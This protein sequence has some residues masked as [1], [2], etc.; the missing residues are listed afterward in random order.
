MNE[1]LKSVW[2][3]TCKRVIAIE[4]ILLFVFFVA[5]ANAAIAGPIQNI[6]S[7]SIFDLKW[8]SAIDEVKQKYPAG[9]LINEY[10][11]IS[12]VI[13]DDRTVLGTSREPS[14][15]I[16]SHLQKSGWMSGNP[17]SSPFSRWNEVHGGSMER[18]SSSEMGRSGEADRRSRLLQ[19]ALKFVFNSENQLFGVAVQFPTRGL[20]SFSQLLSKLNTYFGPQEDNPKTFNGTLIVQ[21]QEDNGYKITLTHTEKLFGKDEL[22]FAVGY[23]EP[24]TTD[25]RKM[26]F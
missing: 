6:F 9:K 22:I 21:W 20:E 23:T 18:N 24:V 14:N 12:Y 17:T 7:D 15:F 25:K 13:K 1:I 4:K 5:I 11:I 3:L 8:L 10:G 26:G 2:M 19:V 16:K